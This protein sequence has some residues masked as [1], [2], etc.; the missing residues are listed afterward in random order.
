MENLSLTS[1][2]DCTRR[3]I[4]KCIICTYVLI[5]YQMLCAVFVAAFGVS[6]AR[7]WLFRRHPWLA[8][9]FERAS[10]TASR[11]A[12]ALHQRRLPLP[13]SRSSPPLAGQRIVF[14]PSHSFFPCLFTAPGCA[15]AQPAH[16]RLARSARSSQPLVP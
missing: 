10:C 6:I 12:Q 5:L 8:G 13:A 16:R 14:C 4:Y 3:I 7:R 11:D 9:C 1:F 2:Y 15:F